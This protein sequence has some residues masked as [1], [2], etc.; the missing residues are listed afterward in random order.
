[1]NGDHYPDILVRT[2][3]DKLLVYQNRQGIMDVD[4]TAVCLN[5]NVNPGEVTSTPNDISG[6]HQLFIQDMDKD[7]N[8]DI[9][10]NDI[11]GDVK[12]FYGGKDSH[13]DGYY[14]STLTSVCDDGRYTRQQNNQ[15]TVK[16]FGL[17]IN[18]DRYI[19]DDS[20]VHRKNMPLPDEST[21]DTENPENNSTIAD[22]APSGYGKD[23][24]LASAKDFVSNTANY[25]VV[26]AKDLSYVDNPLDKVPSYETLAANQIK[27]LPISKLTGENVS[28]Y[29][30][31]EDLN[32]GILL[33]GD[34]VKV[35]TTILSLANNQKI[36]Y[37]DQI[38]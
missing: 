3:S 34:Q 14:I 2:N 15:Q 35:T 26:G 10:T 32:G 19:T 11:A 36:S 9:V 23:Q 25:T 20:L 17:Q 27:Y 1:M 31:Y 6:V 7:G 13:G 21:T 4:G 30:Q 28:V 24:A 33:E 5:T 16:R 29:K 18:P 22:G 12:I 8:L 38:K 37:L